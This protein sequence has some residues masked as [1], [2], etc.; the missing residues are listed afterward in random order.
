MASRTLDHRNPSGPH[1]AAPARRQNPFAAATFT[2]HLHDCPNSSHGS[3]ICLLHRQRRRRNGK[4]A[5]LQVAEL[6]GGDSSAWSIAVGDG[7]KFEKCT[8]VS[9]DQGAAGRRTA[10]AIVCRMRPSPATVTECV[11]VR[12]GET[13]NNRL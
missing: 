8:A 13:E 9:K 1:G 10:G 2:Q 5:K 7:T 4:L 3:E 12:A 6:F 11:P